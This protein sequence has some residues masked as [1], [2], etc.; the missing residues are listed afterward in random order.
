[1]NS[2]E[3]NDLW[4]GLIQ[5]GL[6]HVVYVTSSMSNHMGLLCLQPLKP[7]PKLHANCEASRKLKINFL[8][9]F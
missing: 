8:E 3:V 9:I 5:V 2:T 1:V 6:T 7:S 4:T